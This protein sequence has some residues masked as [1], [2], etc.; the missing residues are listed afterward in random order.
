MSTARRPWLS[1]TRRASADN[2]SGTGWDD[3]YSLVFAAPLVAGIVVGMAAGIGPLATFSA[4]GALVLALVMPYGGLAI[5]A[6]MASL[7]A[8]PG[9]PAP[10]F[11]AALVICILFGCIYRLPI[12]RPR[13]RVTPSAIFLIAFLAY[14]TIQQSPEMLAGYS[15][16]Q[17]HAVGYLYF[18]LMTGFG[19]IVAAV[20]VLRGRPAFP[21]L[22]MALAG[23][24]TAAL[25][26][27]VPYALPAFSG[28]VTGLAGR[29]ESFAGRRNVQ[30]PELHGSVSSDGPHRR[31]RLDGGRSIWPGPDRPTGLRGRPR[32]RAG[33]LVV[34]RRAHRGL[35]GCLC[36]CRNTQQAGRFRRH[37]C[38]TG[39][40]AG[41]L[42]CVRGVAPRQ[43]DGSASAAAFRPRPRATPAGSTG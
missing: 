14:V 23:A 5:L 30:Q 32:L 21:V 42:S 11:H 9:I 41:D 29:S 1:P 33:D 27:L 2:A 26:A 37:L 28:A 34:P 7:V 35:R 31:T 18:Q 12:D 16:T 22:T 24:V 36:A 6:F 43:P 40:R 19:T 13:F 15:H 10:G 38:R 25:V 39:R 3:A 17:D 20:W 4:V 8:P